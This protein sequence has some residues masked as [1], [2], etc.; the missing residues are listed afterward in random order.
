MENNFVQVPLELL[1]KALDASP[2]PKELLVEAQ[3]AIYKSITDALNLK[4]SLNDQL[5]LL[6]TSLDTIE[7]ILKNR[8]KQSQL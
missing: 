3:D 5:D 7:S 6:N 2:A 4:K 1:E 8:E